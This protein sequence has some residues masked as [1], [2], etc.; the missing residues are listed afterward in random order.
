MSDLYTKV[1]A[2]APHFTGYACNGR[3]TREEAIAEA[4]ACYEHQLKEARYFLAM[5]DDDFA[6]RVVRGLY[7]EKLIEELKP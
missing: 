6:V 4:R 7:R 5:T 3:K 2:P 1:R